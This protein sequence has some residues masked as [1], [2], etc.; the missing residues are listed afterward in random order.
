[1]K[2]AILSA[3]LIA[4]VAG[5]V[6]AQNILS[7]GFT[8]MSGSFNSATGVYSAVGMNSGS[9]V[10]VGNVNRHIDPIATAIYGAGTAGGRVGITL[11]VSN[12]VGNNAHGM[13]SLFIEDADGDRFVANVHGDFSLTAPAIFFNAILSDIAFVPGANT[14]STF[15]G[16]SGGSFPLTFAPATAPFQ[17]AT[18]LLFFDTP[19]S[20]FAQNFEARPTQLNGAVIPAPGA[21]ALLGLGGL[22]AARRRR[23]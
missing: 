1:M 20:F 2:A 5:S 10:T 21:A 18:M 15:N 22:L 4:G 13:G 11:N 19:G 8:D 23:R 17:G 14:N 16:P 7:F 6:S 12:I 9:F 3:A